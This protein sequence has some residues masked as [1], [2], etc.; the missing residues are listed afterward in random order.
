MLWI[1]VDNFM[2]VEIILFL[3]ASTT[4][5][6]L[7]L[8]KVLQISYLKLLHLFRFFLLPAVN[9]A[10]AFSTEFYNQQLETSMMKSDIFVQDSSYYC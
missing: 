9:I 3:L 6:Y 2:V 4:L 8:E 5:T 1:S 10:V 7:C